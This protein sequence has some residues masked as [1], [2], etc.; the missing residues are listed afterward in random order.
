MTIEKQYTVTIQV[1]RVG[2]REH[3]EWVPITKDG[4]G[5]VEYGYAPPTQREI[6]V[7]ETIYEQTVDELDIVQ[8]IVAV[9]ENRAMAGR[10]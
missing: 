8:V 2:Y 1:K 6:K 9:N 4:A 10:D 5:N 3:R 7:E